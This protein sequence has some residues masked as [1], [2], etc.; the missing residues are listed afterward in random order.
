[1]TRNK[2]DVTNGI[3]IAKNFVYFLLKTS[4]NDFFNKYENQSTNITYTNP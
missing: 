2:L 1:M 4:Y 3:K